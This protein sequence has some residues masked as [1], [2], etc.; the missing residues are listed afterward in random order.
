MGCT[1]SAQV[2][3]DALSRAPLCVTVIGLPN[4]GKTSLIDYMKGEFDPS[5]PPIQTYGTVISSAF[6]NNRKY[7]LYDV[8]GDL[9]YKVAWGD[10]LKPSDCVVIVL[11]VSTAA[12][13]NVFVKGML[14]E[15]SS[16]ISDEIPVM[17]L[18]NKMDISKDGDIEVVTNLISQSL[19]RNNYKIIECSLV[20][21]LNLDGALRWLEGIAHQV[22]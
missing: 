16:M 20:T 13:V 11:D 7:L 10:S 4:S 2:Y 18:I 6:I 9:E 8:S 1:P 12:V 14:D 21:G 17:C 5:S 19:K 15:V 22:N 3:S